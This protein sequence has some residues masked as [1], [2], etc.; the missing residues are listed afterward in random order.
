MHT[1]MVEHVLKR[2]RLLLFLEVRF[3]LIFHMELTEF[4]DINKFILILKKKLLIKYE[5]K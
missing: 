2:G 3:L 4:R 1:V 5:Y